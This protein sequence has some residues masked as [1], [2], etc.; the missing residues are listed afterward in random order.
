[1]VGDHGVQF[2]NDSVDEWKCVFSGS[3]V[4]FDDSS[5]LRRPEVLPE[6]KANVAASAKVAAR[7]LH[8]AKGAPYLVDLRHGH[9][10]N[11]VR[12]SS[13]YSWVDPSSFEH[14]CRTGHGRAEPSRDIF[15]IWDLRPMQFESATDL[16]PNLC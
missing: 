11:A 13:F 16:R 12:P 1:M 2:R 3:W 15:Y 6:L 10:E 7:R 4:A 8:M 5:E 14:C 9:L